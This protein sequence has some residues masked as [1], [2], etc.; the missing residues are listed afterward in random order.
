[1][2]K[3]SDF[4]I[5]RP[6]KNKN[7]YASAWQLSYKPENK[8]NTWMLFLIVAPQTGE[9]ENGNAS[10]DWKEKSITVK[11]GENDVGE[12][13]SVLDGRQDQAGYKGSLFHQ[14]PKGGNK[15]VQFVAS[16]GGYNLKVSSQDTEK[17]IVGPYY[18]NISHGEGALLLTLLR[19]AVC[20]LYGW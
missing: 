8:Y 14:T 5:Y 6:N 10:F 17:V 4:R 3:P 15:S 18:H 16:D 11:L 20:L 1:M 19:K 7:G 2:D 9:D 12:I 13:M